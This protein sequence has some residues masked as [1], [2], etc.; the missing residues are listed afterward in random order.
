MKLWPFR[1]RKRVN[2]MNVA[3]LTLQHA[4]DD[5]GDRLTRTGIK[6]VVEHKP[7][8]KPVLMTLVFRD[9]EGRQWTGMPLNLY[10]KYQEYYPFPLQW[11]SGR[12][13]DHE[14]VRVE[15]RLEYEDNARRGL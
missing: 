15:V 1:H 13:D 11:L 14:Q 6:Y 7:R 5:F 4:L 2:E 10:G 8:P 9:D 12:P 3:A